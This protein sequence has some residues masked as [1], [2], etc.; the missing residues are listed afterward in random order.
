MMTSLS[1]GHLIMAVKKGFSEAPYEGGIYNDGQEGTVFEY[2]LATDTEN[3]LHYFAGDPTDGGR[4]TDDLTL[5]GSTL[6]GTTLQGGTSN[7]GVIFSIT[8]PEPATVALIML[9]SI[10]LLCRRWRQV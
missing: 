8:V 9:S 1:V 4:P 2:D 7:G 6:Y 3:V 10:A 5:S